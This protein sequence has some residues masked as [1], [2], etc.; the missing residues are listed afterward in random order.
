MCS[1]MDR[2]ESSF[3]S[4]RFLSL[5]AEYFC[6]FSLEDADTMLLSLPVNLLAE[7]HVGATEEIA[8]KDH[9]ILD[10]LRKAGFKINQY[11]VGGVCF[12]SLSN[13]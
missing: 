7:F 6:F 5:T 1:Q 8:K 10:G 12:S 3:L 2:R 9:V 4:F 13:F 11:K